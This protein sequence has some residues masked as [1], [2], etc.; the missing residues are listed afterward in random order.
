MISCIS[1]ATAKI[2]EKKVIEDDGGRLNVRIF[3]AR[4][5]YAAW[6]NKLAGKG[7]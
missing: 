6:G 2:S 4:G 7:F 5:Y 3:D 1:A